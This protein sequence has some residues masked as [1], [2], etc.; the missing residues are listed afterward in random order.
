MTIKIT[1]ILLGVGFEEDSQDRATV[2]QFIETYGY[3]TEDFTN[4]DCPEAK[5]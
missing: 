1:R 3:C 4:A 5:K 2:E